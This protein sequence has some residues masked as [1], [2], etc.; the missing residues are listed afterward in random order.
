M[1]PKQRQ[2]PRRPRRRNAAPARATSPHSRRAGRE[3]RKLQNMPRNKEQ[4]RPRAIARLNPGPNR[5][6][7]RRP[8]SANIF[9]L[10]APKRARHAVRAN[11]SSAAR[12][13]I[14]PGGR[15][16]SRTSGPLAPAA[17]AKKKDRQSGREKASHLPGAAAHSRTRA[18]SEARGK[19]KSPPRHHA[20][21]AGAGT[22]GK[23]RQARRRS[24]AGAMPAAAALPHGA[25]GL[26][27]L[28]KNS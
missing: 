2:P 17:E 3:A 8:V 27:I 10:C 20:R 18:R 5:R 26:G 11:A 24:L 15:S 6:S 23:A 19:D 21:K 28:A 9:P 13:P 12:R 1:N 22:A 25:K 4:E 16:M 7:N 14:A